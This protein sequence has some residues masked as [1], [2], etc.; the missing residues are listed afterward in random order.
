M[1]D[2]NA[3]R[4]YE[5]LSE[6]TRDIVLF[7]RPDGQILEAN[8]A[9][10]GAYGYTRAELLTMRVHD[11]R[12]EEARPDVD[13]QMAEARERGLTFE[14]VHRRKDGTTF[15]VEVSANPSPI[16]GVMLNLVRD[17]TL[18]KQ[19]ETT[20]ALLNEMD[21]HI[22]ERQPLPMIL[23]T[24]C[25]KLSALFGYS[26]VWI[27]SKQPD[28]RVSMLAQAGA[29]REFLQE[30]AIRWDDSPEGLGPTG[31]AI[32]TGLVQVIPVSEQ[33]WE[34]FREPAAHH[35]FKV[36]LSLPLHVRGETIGALTF[37]AV[38]EDA[39]DVAMT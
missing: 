7:L 2:H 22:L 33:A 12:A 36:A 11:L 29:E 39:F 18:R 13:A 20:R 34:S 10:V 31:T 28:G 6:L 30:V 14:T 38:R 15:P 16:G 24:L 32:R 37:Y 9:A 17:I 25:Q 8:R 19:I 26:L 5:L 27:G 3:L 1:Q 35:G 23:Q 21:Q 4:R